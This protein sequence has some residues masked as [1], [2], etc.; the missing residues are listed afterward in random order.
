MTRALSSPRTIAALALIGLGIAA[1]LTWTHYAGV[2][3]ICASDGGCEEVQSSKYAELA[4]VPVAL[5]G[6]VGYAAILVS[7]ALRGDLGRTVTAFLGLVGL[8]FSGYL[9]YLELV[10]IDATCQWCLA[11]ALVMSAIAVAATVRL[12]SAPPAP[13][14]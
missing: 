9:T 6:V 5:I 12:L 4:G 2:E 8:G 3:P 1:Y 13:R 10:E 11:S 14:E 7:L